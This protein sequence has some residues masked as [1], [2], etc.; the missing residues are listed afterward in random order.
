VPDRASP[1]TRY[2]PSGSGGLTSRGSRTGRA[3]SRS[4]RRSRR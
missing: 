2:G 4:P 3:R 1:T